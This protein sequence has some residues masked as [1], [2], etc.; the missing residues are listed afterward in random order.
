MKKRYMTPTIEVEEY[1]LENQLLIVSAPDQGISYGGK[2][3]TGTIDP[4]SREFD[5]W[6]DE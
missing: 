2:D 6:W 1:S 3:E 5:D 4:A